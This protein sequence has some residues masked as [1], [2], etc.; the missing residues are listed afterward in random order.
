MDLKEKIKYEMQTDKSKFENY[1]FLK[2]LEIIK[3]LTI[4]YNNKNL[5]NESIKTTE[6]SSE[7]GEMLSKY[8]INNS[9][10]KNKISRKDNLKGNKNEIIHFGINNHPEI[11]KDGKKFKG[12]NKKAPKFIEYNC[13]Y[14]TYKNTNINAPKIPLIINID[15]KLNNFTNQGEIG[16][17][18]YM[19]NVFTNKYNKCEDFQKVSI[20]PHDKLSH[21]C[22]NEN[23]YIKRNENNYNAISVTQRNKHKFITIIYISP[24]QKI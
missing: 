4:S 5:S 10:N 6:Y 16:E 2:N 12:K 8:L 17:K 20:M 3:K 15:F 23:L 22:I 1:N 13:D 7:S 21:L 11:N 14:F 19:K 24:K 18:E 9:Q